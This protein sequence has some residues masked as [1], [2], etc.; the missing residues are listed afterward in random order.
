[1]P[2]KQ[3]A[4]SRPPPGYWQRGP[5]SLPEPMSCSDSTSPCCRPAPAA[6]ASRIR[7]ATLLEEHLSEKHLSAAKAAGC[8]RWHWPCSRKMEEGGS[9]L[10]SPCAGFEGG[11]SGEG[12]P[13]LVPPQATTTTASGCARSCETRSSGLASTSCDAGVPSYESSCYPFFSAGVEWLGESGGGRSQG[14]WDQPFMWPLV[15]ASRG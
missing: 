4:C 3:R 15:G 7:R 8:G 1:M 9:G 10:A 2:K 12:V 11:M 13:Y 5:T 14:V 6:A